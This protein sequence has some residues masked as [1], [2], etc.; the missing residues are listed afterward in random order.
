[1]SNHTNTDLYERAV[2]MI[3]YFQDKLPAQL[4]ESDIANNDLELLQRHIVEAEAEA[5]RQEFYNN[6]DIR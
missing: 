5:A 3:D 6:D 2:Y 1:M 4:I